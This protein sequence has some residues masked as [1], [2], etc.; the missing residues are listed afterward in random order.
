MITTTS[1]IGDSETNSTDTPD[2]N[3]LIGISADEVDDTTEPVDVE[4]EVPIVPRPEDLTGNV[5]EMRYVG[6]NLPKECNKLE[7]GSM[8]AVFCPDLRYLMHT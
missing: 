5:E 1:E 2:T 8:M 4:P 3:T 6:W 7:I